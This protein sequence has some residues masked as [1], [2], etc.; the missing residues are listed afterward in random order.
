MKEGIVI[1]NKPAGVTSHDVVSIVRRRFKMR[2]VGHSG[3]L[4][5]LATGVLIILLGHSTKLF[6]KFVLFDKVYNATLQLGLKTTTADIEGQVLNQQPWNHITRR[7]VD[8]VFK[9]FEGDIKQ[10]PPMVSALK[11]KGIRLYKLARSGVEVEREPRDIRINLLKVVDFQAPFVKFYLEC[12]K[13]TYVR[14]LAQDAGE[15][16]GCGACITQIQ[17]T[18][19]GPFDILNSVKLEELNETHINRWQG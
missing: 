18:K 15:I 10:I 6:N 13:G 7:Q 14:Q 2:Q 16:L 11:F 8:E 9:R 12:S 19:V 5:P 4:D 17:R 1:I 3:T